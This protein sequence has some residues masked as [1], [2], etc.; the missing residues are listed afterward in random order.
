MQRKIRRGLWAGK[1]GGAMMSGDRVIF[2]IEAEGDEVGRK[3]IG[4]DL[5]ANHRC[6]HRV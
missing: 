3:L 2:V 6:R 1:A 5:M 4:D